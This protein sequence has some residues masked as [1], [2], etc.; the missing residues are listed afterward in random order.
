MKEKVAIVTGATGGIGQAI[1]KRLAKDG[2]DMVIHYHRNKEA[3]EALREACQDEGVKAISLS[4]DLADKDACERLIQTSLDSFGRIDVLVNNSGITKDGLIMRQSEEDFMDVVE[5]N[6]LSAWRLQKLV[7]RPMMKQRY[8]RIINMS[9]VVGLCGNAGQANYAASK[10]GLNGIT[11]SLA[12]ELGSRD[13]TVNAIAPGFIATEMTQ[14]LD[15]SWQDLIKK[16]I[17]LGR[18]GQPEEVA[19]VV[20]FLAGPDASYISGQVI[21]VDGALAV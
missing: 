21:R 19:G 11:K 16:Q 4:G 14:G 1:V 10:A 7:V 9:S 17:A 15:Q 5:V 6:M 20:S 18:F 12:K 13:I 2:F 3:A 8:G